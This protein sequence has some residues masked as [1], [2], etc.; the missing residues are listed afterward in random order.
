M[1]ALQRLERFRSDSQIPKM[2]VMQ[3]GPGKQFLAIAVP[4]G[5][6]AAGHETQV[7]PLRIY[8]HNAAITAGE[9][10]QLDSVA[11]GR[12]GAKMP[13]KRRVPRSPRWLARQ[14]RASR[15]DRVPTIGANDRVTRSVLVVARQDFATGRNLLNDLALEH[16]HPTGDCVFQERH[17]KQT[18]ADRPGGHGDLDEGTARRC[19]Q[20]PV[21][22]VMRQSANLHGYAES[23]ESRP[24]VRIYHI[25]AHFVSRELVMFEQCDSQPTLRAQRRRCRTGRPAPDNNDV[26]VPHIAPARWQH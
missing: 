22:W 11:K 2:P 5:L 21:N 8:A 26:K 12:G 16:V 24:A 15:H 3:H 23:V 4:A 18:P 14:T 20:R 17:V 7:Q 1:S 6:R 10:M 25:A 19:E 9:E 13:L